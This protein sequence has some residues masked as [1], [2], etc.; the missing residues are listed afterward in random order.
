MAILVGIFLITKDLNPKTKNG[1]RKKRNQP[2]QADLPMG[3]PQ[4]VMG[5][6]YTGLRCF[7]NILTSK[8][9][10]L[11]KRKKERYLP[12]FLLQDGVFSEKCILLG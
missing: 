6:R 1:G 9:D 3:D 2:G 11:K 4:A 10:S 5:R 7:C 8:I 12:S